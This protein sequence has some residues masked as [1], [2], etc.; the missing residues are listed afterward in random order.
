MS[1]PRKADSFVGVL[2]QGK[3]ISSTATNVT[4]V[5]KQLLVEFC[6][7]NFG[8]PYVDDPSSLSSLDEDLFQHI[9]QHVHSVTVDAA[10]NEIAACENMKC[11]D[12]CTAMEGVAFCPNVRTVVR[13]K[14]HAS[15]RIL[16]RPWA[17]DPYLE[18]VAGVLVSETNSV[19]Q[20]VQHS[21]DLRA[22]FEECCKNATRKATTAEFKHL[23]AAKHRYESLA[24]PLTRMCLHWE[25][26]INFLLKLNI[27]RQSTAAAA[28]LETIDPEMMLQ[29]GL[30][31]D[32]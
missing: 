23:R 5:T 28:L 6:T 27:E 22:W 9:R 12:S 13:D 7:P 17:C 1:S 3:I 16:Q 29:A 30:L 14:A 2:G 21:D 19:A 26:V 32:H 10:E 20:M 25:A 24:A 8:C 18:L 4:N 31:A 11:K 15:R